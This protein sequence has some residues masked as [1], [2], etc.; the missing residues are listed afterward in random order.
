[1]IAFLEEI[2]ARRDVQARRGVARTYG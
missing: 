2:N 1:M